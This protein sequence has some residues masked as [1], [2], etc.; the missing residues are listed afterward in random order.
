MR[1]EQKAVP[2][3]TAVRP[4][5]G[6]NPERMPPVFTRAVRPSR[7]R[8]LSPAGAPRIVVVRSFDELAEHRAALDHLTADSADTNVFYESILAE[9]AVRSFGAGRQ[10]ELVLVYRSDPGAP[11]RP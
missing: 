10:L 11:H 4:P 7:E 3:A 9:P 1:S 5:A 8:L 6:I 2:S